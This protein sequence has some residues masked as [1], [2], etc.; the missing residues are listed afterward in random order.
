MGAEGKL[1]ARKANSDKNSDGDRA[2][3]GLEECK[4]K[5]IRTS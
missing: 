5:C 3:R 1:K 4:A 2:V